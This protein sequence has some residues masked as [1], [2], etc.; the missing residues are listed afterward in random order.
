MI[1]LLLYCAVS[2]FATAI[3]F[4]VLFPRKSGTSPLSY[5]YEEYK[6]EF[7]KTEFVFRSGRNQ[8]SG[9]R[10]DAESPKG[11]IVV[12][13]GIGAGADAHL[14]EITEF[15]RDGWSVATWNATGV[16]KSEGRGIVGL[17]Q[18]R[19]DLSAFLRFLKTEVALNG[20]PVVLYGHSAGAYAAASV[21][22]S[23]PEIRAAVC[24]SGFDR[25]VSL[26]YGHAKDRVGFLADAEY[27]FLLLY[28]GL[29]FGPGANDS[30]RAAV[31]AVST[32]VF[33]IGGDSDDLVPIENS[34]I[35]NPEDYTNPNV[36]TLLI[37][38]EYRN[39]HATPW[40][41]VGAARYRAELD[42]PSA[43]DKA[44]ANELDPAFT[45][46]VLRFYEES[47]R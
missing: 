9:V 12:I 25:P 16:G 5:T 6:P 40:L 35:R 7:G 3:V 26:M 4:R 31:N 42:D 39:E 1:A 19:C 33:I 14:P 24:I 36:R 10:Y 22:A 18:I 21:L 34:L 44:A 8:L 30:A 13:N 29:V 20:L 23:H 47:I 45:E 41:S 2:M 15:I 11:L 32:P 17:Q 38:S 37:T 27:P 28:S 43:S 46:T